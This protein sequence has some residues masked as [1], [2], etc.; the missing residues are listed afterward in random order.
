MQLGYGNAAIFLMLQSG[1]N[2]SS[3]PKSL[4]PYKMPNQGL[5]TL[6]TNSMSG[7]SE[8]NRGEN[9]LKNKC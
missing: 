6:M 4:L 2:H 5:S 9:T 3:F 7:S 1:R 8:S